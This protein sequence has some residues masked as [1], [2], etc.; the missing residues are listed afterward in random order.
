MTDEEKK[1]DA[2][3]NKIAGTILLFLFGLLGFLFLSLRSAY[4]FI[5]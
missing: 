3:A 1:Y 2:F 5:L 4:K